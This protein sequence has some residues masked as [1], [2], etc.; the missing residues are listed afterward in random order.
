MHGEMAGLELISTAALR[1]L[2]AHTRHLAEP[3]AV[4]TTAPHVRQA[5]ATTPGLR[6]Y[7]TLAAALAGLPTTAGPPDLRPETQ[8]GPPAVGASTEELRSEVFGLRAKARTHAQIGTAQGVLYERYRLNSP[9]QGFD[10]LRE[11]SQHL[12]VPLR[13]LASAVLTAP[14]PPTPGGDWF[15][16]R[17][18]T[19]PPTLGLLSTGGL[20]TRDRR[21]VLHTAVNDALTLTDADAD[22]VELH[23]TDPAQDHALVLED[24]AA[25][26]PAYLDTIALVTAPPALCARARDRAQAV[27]V[28]DIATEPAFAD[29]PPGRAALAAGTR[30]LHAQP[31]VTVHGDT[32]AVITLH[33]R[34]HGLWMTNA[35]HTALETLAAD[36]ATWRSWYRR[37]VILD[38]LEHLHTH[39]P[40]QQLIPGAVP[41]R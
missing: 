16:G 4:V 19:P 18:H 31:A 33:R 1:L 29:S 25:L 3:V 41:D 27:T 38:A 6:L 39:A 30:A 15:P 36:I 26:T 7:P 8:T 37:T 32:L 28:A 23:L 20:D 17:R 40:H 35:Q 12:N 21:Q 14:P 24:H 5:L 13:V 10:L 11:A 22:A 9:T 2:D 34:E